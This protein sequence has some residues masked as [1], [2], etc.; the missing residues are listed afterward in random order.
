VGCPFGRRAPD[1]SAAFGTHPALERSLVDWLR[2][3]PAAHQELFA[4]SALRRARRT[5]LARN[6]ALSLA[7]HPSEE[8]REALE[9]AL[10]L[11]PSPR[12]REAAGW[13]LARAHAADRGAS[14]ALERAVERETDPAAR[15]DLARSRAALGG[16]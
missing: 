11:D 12:V 4:G 16:P 9:R 2:H 3:D 15:A 5:G 14:A 1:A 6:A 7:R 10:A 8:G 13:S